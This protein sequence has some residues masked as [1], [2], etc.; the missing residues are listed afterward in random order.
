MCVTPALR[1]GCRLPYAHSP[2]LCC[3]SFQF[4]EDQGGHVCG[5]SNTSTP[6][7]ELSRE[8]TARTQ[9]CKQPAPRELDPEP[10]FYASPDYQ[11]HR[12]ATSS[13]CALSPSGEDQK[14]YPQT[15]P[16]GSAESLL[17]AAWPPLG[18]RGSESL[19]GG[20][21]TRLR[22]PCLSTRVTQARLL[23]LRSSFPPRGKFYTHLA[24][25][26][27]LRK[28][29]HRSRGEIN[30]QKAILPISP[31]GTGTMQLSSTSTSGQKYMCHLCP[32][33]CSLTAGVPTLAQMGRVLLFLSL[34]SSG[35]PPRP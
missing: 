24:T 3:D 33:P 10:V 4:T 12:P 8:S 35:I 34:H 9:V 20:S 1:V 5:I 25:V 13:S 17:K 26:K 32:E 15:H 27:K 18:L 22:E 28:K 23:T 2:L 30:I 14:G 16:S 31:L 7:T 21:G 29:I 19:S 11:K 6:V